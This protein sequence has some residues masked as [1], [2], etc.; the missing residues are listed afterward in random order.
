MPTIAKVQMLFSLTI[1]D[2]YPNLPSYVGTR[3]SA[4]QKA[5]RMR[6]AHDRIFEKTPYDYELQMIYTPIITLH[7]PYNVALEFDSM[8]VEF[9]GIPFAMQVFRNSKKQSVDLV[10][11]EMMT[12]DNTL[13]NRDE[14][15]IFA[16]SLHTKSSNKPGSTSFRLLPGEVILFSPYID[17][18]STWAQEIER[19]K[20]G[21][22]EFWDNHLAK[23]GTSLTSAIKAMPGWRGFGVGYSLDWLGDPD[24][25]SAGAGGWLG[26][27]VVAISDKIHVEFAPISIPRNNNKFVV[28]LS[29]TVAGTAK[30]KVSAI[31]MDAAY[32]SRPSSSASSVRDLPGSP[33]ISLDC[34]GWLRPISSASSVRSR[35]SSPPR[36]SPCMQVLTT[37][38]PPPFPTGTQPTGLATS[39]S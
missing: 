9:I 31:E 24:G 29:G 14:S 5:L 10:P 2:I 26:D 18:K 7:N 34:L 6:G 12:A 39:D 35:P 16:M 30:K 19:E 32:G 15:K 38:R 8:N 23:D 4:A 1:R 20:T 13:G 33:L 3:L 22:Q 27:L 36:T 28:Q 11:F 17:P 21:K 25:K 37:A